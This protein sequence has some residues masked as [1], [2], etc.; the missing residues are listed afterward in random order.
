MTTGSLPREDAGRSRTR[1]D[2]E[3]IVLRTRLIAGAALVIVSAACSQYPSSSAT[4]PALGAATTGPSEIVMPLNFGT[5]MHGSNETP[6]HD[7]DATGQ[8]ILKVSA[9]RQSIEYKL[10][11]SNIYNAI[12][13]HI[14]MG[15]VGQAGPPV[16]FLY[17]TVP[18]G[19]GRHDGVLATGTLTADSLFG[20]LA[21]QPLS[22]LI[23]LIESGNAYANI[24]TNDGIAPANTGPGDFPAGEIRGQVRK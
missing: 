1:G 19:G 20:P 3:D 16:A 23:D 6:A 7:T 9:D 4:S 15:P 2:K 24:H 10:I 8:L 14:H 17:G 12:A 22:A 21:G 11:A 5:H 18:P 13:S